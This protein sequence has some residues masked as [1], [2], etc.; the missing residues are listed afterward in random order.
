MSKLFRVALYF[1]T[2]LTG[3]IL[4][5]YITEPYGP[6]VSADSVDYISTAESLI[7]NFHFTSYDGHPFLSWP[8]LYPLI[9]A[10]LSLITGLDVF[11]VGGLLNAICYGIIMVLAGM[12][13]Q[14]TFGGSLAWF[15]VGAWLSITSFSI[16]ALATNITTDPLFIIL[17]LCYTLLGSVF[18]V[19]PKTLALLGLSLIAAIFGL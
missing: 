19:E 5:I 8:P 6:G 9:L 4:V 13:F 3:F 16:L 7:R 10:G 1:A 14:R 11:I 18:L 17:V 15:L 2:S 12:L